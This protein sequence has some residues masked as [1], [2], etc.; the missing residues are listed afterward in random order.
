MQDLLILDRELPA[1][2]QLVQ[3]GEADC[4]RNASL[5]AR[6]RPPEWVPRWRGEGPPPPWVRGW[7]QEARTGFCEVT[8]SPESLGCGASDRKGTFPLLPHEAMSWADAAHACMLRCL[9][10]GACNYIS[11]SMQWQ[12]CSWFKQCSLTRLRTDVPAFRTGPRITRASV[13][14]Q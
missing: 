4:A 11:V 9:A 2:K 13:A 12:D 6:E 1:L 8:D 7:L 5:F 14:A 3:L 10:C